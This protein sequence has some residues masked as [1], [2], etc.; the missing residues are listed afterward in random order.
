M[1]VMDSGQMVSGAQPCLC[2]E[3]QQ[4][5][6][7][8]PGERSG[9]EPPHLVEG[10]PSNKLP[11]G[12]AANPLPSPPRQPGNSHTQRHLRQSRQEMDGVVGGLAG[13]TGK[14]WGQR[15]CGVCFGIGRGGGMF[16]EYCFEA[17]YFPQP[18]LCLCVLLSLS[19]LLC[20]G[21]AA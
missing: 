4:L 8:A 17:G 20:S 21:S 2:Q 6:A 14:V 5:K 12:L 9:I 13:Y 15:D 18:H 19:L 1:A 3:G 10:G 16:W 7:H 11:H